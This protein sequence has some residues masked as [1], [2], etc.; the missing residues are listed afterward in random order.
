MSIK[1]ILV[2]TI[3]FLLLAGGFATTA[4]ASEYDDTAIES[5]VVEKNDT[6]IQLPDDMRVGDTYKETVSVNG[7]DATYTVTKNSEQLDNANDGI[8]IM[9]EIVDYQTVP[10]S[11]TASFTVRGEFGQ[12]YAEFELYTD[13]GLIDY[14]LPGPYFFIMGVDSAE[15]TQ[16]STRLATYDFQTSGSVD[17]INGPTVGL[18]V[19][20]RIKSSVNQNINTLTTEIY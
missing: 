4:S 3:A 9:S 13:D 12:Q 17:W 1:K 11:G 6:G 19:R 2:G 14:V 5:S 20:A 8:S 16:R 10:V 18:G 15:L 7:E